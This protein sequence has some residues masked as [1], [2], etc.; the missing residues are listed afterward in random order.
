MLL[1]TGAAIGLWVE[2]DS[3]TIV[4]YFAAFVN[5]LMLFGPLAAAGEVIRARSA[6]GLSLLPLV[7]TLTA[8]I[9]WCSYGVYIRE[10]PAI[11]P[12]ALGILFGMAQITLFAWAKR[13]EKKVEDVGLT[14]EFEPISVSPTTMS[15]REAPVGSNQRERVMSITAILEGNP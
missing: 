10:I 2:Q 13:Q 11:I 3:N 5:I 6:R 7:M 14:S 15:S 9:I 1:L 12:N 4:G 8:S